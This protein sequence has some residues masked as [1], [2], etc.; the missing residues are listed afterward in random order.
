[1]GDWYFPRRSFSLCFFPAFFFPP[2]FSL[3]ALFPSRYFRLG[4]NRRA[5]N[6]RGKDLAGKKT[7]GE[8]TGHPYF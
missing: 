7:G 4:K 8:S 1:M 2:V 6:W 5:K 3:L